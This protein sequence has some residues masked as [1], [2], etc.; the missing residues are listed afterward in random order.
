MKKWELWKRVPPYGVAW[1]EMDKGV[2]NDYKLYTALNPVVTNAVLAFIYGH[3][4][5]QGV[6]KT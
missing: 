3:T 1:I 4:L 2:I 6:N 5:F